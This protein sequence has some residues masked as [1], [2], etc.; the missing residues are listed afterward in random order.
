[1]STKRTDPAGAQPTDP[2]W[3]RLL[4]LLVQGPDGQC[5]RAILLVTPLLL[6]MTGL[7][8]VTAAAAPVNW[9]G[10]ALGVGSLT[11]LAVSRS[12]R[13]IPGASEPLMRAHTDSTRSSRHCGTRAAVRPGRQPSGP[14]PTDGR[15]GVA[16]PTPRRDAGRTVS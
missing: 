3:A 6:L 4:F 13:R 9:V 2:P 8:V 1:V 12:R 15:R 11:T 5:W 7:V 10:G 14:L 16:R